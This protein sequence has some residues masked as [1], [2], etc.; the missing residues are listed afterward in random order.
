M[1]KT[2]N[3][4]GIRE[5]CLSLIKALHEKTTANII[6]DGERLKPFPRRLEQDK[7]ALTTSI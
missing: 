5:N 7:G 6:L 3:K 4:L 2:L 1:I